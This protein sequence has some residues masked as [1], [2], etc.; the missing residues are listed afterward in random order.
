MLLSQRSRKES[1]GYVTCSSCYSRMQP[2][3]A[4]K[5]TPPKNA[6]A[7]GFVIGCFPSKN[8]FTNKD[9][10]KTKRDIKEDDHIDIMLPM[11]APVRPYGYIFVWTA[12]S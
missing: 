4:K 12:G 8:T 11:F 2:K 7:N 10:S 9:G 1:D 6:M 5:K 3:M